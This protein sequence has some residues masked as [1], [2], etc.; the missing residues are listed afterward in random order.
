MYFYHRFNGFNG[1]RGYARYSGLARW[2]VGWVRPVP[3]GT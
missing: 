3:Y 1:F 2:G